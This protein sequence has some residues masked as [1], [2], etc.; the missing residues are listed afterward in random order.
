M[1]NK[2][3]NKLK[4]PASSLA[5]INDLLLDPKSQLV[6]DVLKVIAKHG[7]IDAINRKS[8]E[9]RKLPNLMARLRAMKS[10]SCPCAAGWSGGRSG[11]SCAT[12]SGSKAGQRCIA[13]SC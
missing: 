4:I 6:N 11:W 3:R 8:A 13:S 9:A 7:T 5:A 2:L 1:D 10:A 12:S